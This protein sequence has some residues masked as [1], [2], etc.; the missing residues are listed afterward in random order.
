MQVI[1]KNLLRSYKKILS[2][3]MVRSNLCFDLVSISRYIESQEE[4]NL[5]GQMSLVLNQDCIR[6]S[7]EKC[8]DFG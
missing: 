1:F 5:D 8:L 7:I 2:R 6:S 4:E 3:G